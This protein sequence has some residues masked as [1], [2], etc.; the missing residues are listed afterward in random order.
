M[1]L[2]SA[3]WPERCSSTCA[4][5]CC[6]HNL[7]CCRAT[8]HTATDLGYSGTVGQAQS[9]TSR[10]KG[11]RAYFGWTPP[12]RLFV[13]LLAVRC[14]RPHDL[15]FMVLF[16]IRTEVVVKILHLQVYVAFLLHRRVEAKRPM[17]ELVQRTSKVIV[18]FCRTRASRQLREVPG[19]SLCTQP[20]KGK[21]SFPPPRPHKVASSSNGGNLGIDPGSGPARTMALRA[22][23][24]RH[25]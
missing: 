4:T 5:Q 24:L 14:L 8:R 17:K 19:R 7:K 23:H 22:G 11:R 2:W 25:A 15:S 1:A 9:P 3:A 20:L 6:S 18:F 21:C 12:L 10:R 13:L 16:L